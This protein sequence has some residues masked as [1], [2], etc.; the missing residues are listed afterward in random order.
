MDRRVF[1]GPAWKRHKKDKEA[2]D[3]RQ[4]RLAVRTK[5]TVECVAS[6]I[7]IK[8]VGEWDPE[9]GGEADSAFLS[10]RK[11]FFISIIFLPYLVFFG[12]ARGFLA[13]SFWFNSE[14]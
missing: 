7:Q 5:V 9:G 6:G 3:D 13:I 10:R 12:S 2:S 1:K 8:Q 11:A 14:Y 4:E